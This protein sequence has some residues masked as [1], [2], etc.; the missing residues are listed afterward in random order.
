MLD[1]F[2]IILLKFVFLKAQQRSHFSCTLSV[3]VAL[4]NVRKIKLHVRLN[5]AYSKIKNFTK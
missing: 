2:V 5:V 4:Q 3:R 1:A